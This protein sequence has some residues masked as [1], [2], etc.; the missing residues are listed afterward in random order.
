[1]VTGATGT[2]GDA[3]ARR[4][5]ADGASTVVCYRDNNVAAQQ[6]VDD[7][8][9]SGG[10]AMAERLDVT[11][12]TQVRRVIF[13]VASRL[14]RLDVLVNNAGV[15][16]RSAFTDIVEADWDATL[17]TNLKGYFLCS[18]A[19]ARVMVPQQSGSIVHVSSTNETVASDRCTAYAVSKGGVRLLMRQMALELGPH[20]IR[21]N[22]VC[23]GMVE[24]AMNCDELTDPVFRSSALGRIP[25]G[26]FALPT[27]VA[28][29]VAYLVS[30][31]AGFVNGASLAVDG[32]KVVA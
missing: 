24:T 21:T 26:R 5:A 15:M 10:I 12:A 19:A 32:G 4:L 20:G 17:D 27:D 23:P 11:D 31:E 16:R 6:A 13:G 25:L 18:Q 22:T 2:I 8:R 1:M 28:S 30:D 14:G 3:I 29:A 7:I 9:S